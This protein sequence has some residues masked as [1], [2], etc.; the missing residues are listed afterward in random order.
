MRKVVEKALPSKWN[1]RWELLAAALREVGEE[2]SPTFFLISEGLTVSYRGLEFFFVPFGETIGY[3]V[4]VASPEDHR[5][6]Q[7]LLS[8]LS[9]WLRRHEEGRR[10]HKIEDDTVVESSSQTCDDCHGGESQANEVEGGEARPEG[11]RSEGVEN[12]SAQQPSHSSGSGRGEALKERHSPSCESTSPEEAE[13]PGPEAGLGGVPDRGTDFS[14]KSASADFKDRLVGAETSPSSLWSSSE[15]GGSEEL[16]SAQKGAEE[17]D[18]ELTDA[19]EREGERAG[20]EAERPPAGEASF[21]HSQQVDPAESSN[22]SEEDYTSSLIEEVLNIEVEPARAPRRDF[23]LPYLTEPSPLERWAGKVN[24]RK[25]RALKKI[26]K[27]AVDFVSNGR[28]TPRIDSK[29]ALLN[30][31]KGRSPYTAFKT[32]MEN[33][34]LLLMVDV[35][36]SMHSFLDLVPYFVELAKLWRDEVILIINENAFPAT[37]VVDG[38]E[39]TFWECRWEKVHLF[40]DELIRKYNIKLVVALTDWDGVSVYRKLL[41]KTPA[42]MVALDTYCCATYDKP[43]KPNPGSLEK[44]LPNELWGVKDKIAYWY[45]VGDWDGVITVLNEEL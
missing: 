4:T 12:S 13:P 15:T 26:F 17:G 27:R 24:K 14:L 39:A 16:N 18:D 41:E 9:A 44:Y 10:L 3:F 43:I 32:D 30:M 36:G 6:I 8:K 42:Q 40:Y 29:K 22:P 37:V 5:K 34:R 20:Q 28:A 31:L 2:V 1:G 21:A 33:G 11:Q 38:V 45:A 23:N 7:S 19:G 25:F 35:S